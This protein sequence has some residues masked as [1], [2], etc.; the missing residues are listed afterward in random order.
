MKS[1]TEEWEKI[2]QKQEWGRYPSENVIRFVARNYYGMERSKVRILDFGCGAGANTWYLAREGFDVYAFDGSETAVKRAKDYLE[3]EGYNDVKF[4]VMDGLELNYPYDFFDCIIDNACIY[5]NTYSVIQKMYKEVF[6]ILK[7]GGKLFSSCFG[8]ATEGFESG[9]ML[10]SNTYEN[11]KMGALAGR[12][13]AHFF[14]KEQLENV[15]EMVGFTNIIID[16]MSY[17]DNGHR[18]E[19]FIL[20]A[21]K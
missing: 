3:T 21:T 10:E 5:A 8:I 18:I 12:A 20:Q 1:F 7:K 9:N 17:T 11:I 2:H 6:A 13:C 16:E 19:M 15:V 4:A 14:T